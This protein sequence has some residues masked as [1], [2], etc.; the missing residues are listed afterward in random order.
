VGGGGGVTEPVQVPALVTLPNVD[1]VAAGTWNLSSGEATFT[2]EDLASAVEAAQCPAVGAPV[3][4][5]GHTDPRFDGEPSVGRVTNMAVSGAK[6]TGDLAGMPG[7]LGAVLGSAYPSRS[8]EGA[9]DFKC[10]IGHV[11]PFVITALALLGVAMPGVGVL[12]GLEDVAALYGLTDVQAA[13]GEP[14]EQWRLYVAGG[15]MAGKALAA[16]VT[17][18]DVRRA[19]YEQSDTPWSYW[20]SEIQMDPPQL[21]VSDDAT[22][23]TYR[24]PLTIKGGAITFGTAQE[25]EVEYVDV[26]AAQAGER[27]RWVSAAAS[28][29]GVVHAWSASTQLK[30]MGDDPSKSALGKM[31][32]LPADTKS[33][34]KLP[35]HV[36]AADGTV[37]A[38]DVGGCQAAIGVIN[39]ARGGLTG[40][41]AADQ[42][43]AYNHLAAHVKDAGG[44]PAEYG[45]PAAAAG[46]PDP[47]A[48]SPAADCANSGHG[49]ADGSHSHSHPAMG[50][51]GGDATHTHPHTHAGDAVHDHAHATAGGNRKGASEVEFTDEQKASL[52]AALGLAEDAELDESTL[53][54]SV[55]S[56][57]ERA[58]AAPPAAAAS[59][60]LSDRQMVIDKDAWDAMQTRTGK[61]EAAAK[62]RE[63]EQRDEVI[64]QAIRDGKFSAAS[65]VHYE[66]SWDLDP[67]NA[68]A[69]IA[70]LRKNVVPVEDVGASGGDPDDE[71]NP[72]YKGL[73]PP[74]SWSREPAPQGR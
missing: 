42:K 50:S 1:L 38:A 14:R 51:Q 3:I 62:Q 32:A 53:L 40:V 26:A 47:A 52:R 69:V 36:C 28:R 29:E 10:Q 20:I 37:G 41:S 23:K 59:G 44:T 25:V 7:W 35:H 58:T 34:S 65:R 48:A 57:A 67:D 22:A 72:D 4:K 73:F 70:S 13:V 31:F 43:K 64:A 39:G 49:P 74:G 68:R 16:G 66:R 63:R 6:V 30:N 15:A 2:P 9:W 17:V 46:D 45:G 21:I 8:I 27:V 55:S 24:V 11:H 12:G 33:D 61:L 56:L 5:L 71:D 19:Y 60:R 54:A 18:E